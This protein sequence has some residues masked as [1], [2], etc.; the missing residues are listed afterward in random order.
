MIID[1]GSLQGPGFEELPEWIRTTFVCAMD[2]SAEDHIL[3]QAAFQKHCDNGE[4]FGLLLFLLANALSAVSKTINF[5]ESATKDDIAHGLMMAWAKGC[6]G[7]TVYRD[8]CRAFQVLN[9][10]G[11][12][13]DKLCPS[14]NEDTLVHTGGCIECKCGY[15]ACSL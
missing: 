5:P 14:C 15:A 6:K 8:K 3:M 1:R 10:G 4:G 13:T 9:V 7:T 12:S 11:A 2:I